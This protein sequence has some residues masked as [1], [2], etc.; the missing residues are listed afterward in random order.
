MN[1]KLI[2]I[3]INLL[4]VS[5]FLFFHTG[6][7]SSEKIQILALNLTGQTVRAQ[8]MNRLYLQHIS[9]YTSTVK[10]F[11]LLLDPVLQ[12]QIEIVAASDDEA[13]RDFVR[14]AEIPILVS[15]LI[16]DRGDFVILRIYAMAYDVPHNG[17]LVANHEVKIPIFDKISA[18]ELS[19]IVEEHTGRFLVQLLENYKRPYEF[20]VK[21]NSYVFDQTIKTGN[22]DLYA[23]ENRDDEIITFSKIQNVR[24]SKSRIQTSL[25]DGDYFITQTY[26]DESSELSDFIYGRKRETVYATGSV[27]NTTVAVIASPFLSLISPIGTPISY[28]LTSDY[29]GLGLWT[30]NNSP[31]LYIATNG[32]INSPEKRENDNKNISRYDYSTYYYSYYYFLVSGMALY[33]DAAGQESKKDASN[34]IPSQQ[35]LGDESIAVYLSIMGNGAG[36]FYK[37]Y[38]TWGYFYFHADNLLTLSSL[39]FLSDSKDYSSSSYQKTEHDKTTGYF[40]LGAAAAVRV[41]EIIHSMH[42]RFNIDNGEDLDH[43]VEAEPLYREDTEKGGMFFGLSFKKLL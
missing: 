23:I 39:Y 42:L 30:V 25:Q 32:F 16:E 31:Y 8:M 28:Y 22:Y 17:Q 13:L 21:G 15:G 6:L 14:R 26:S 37:G 38:R 1:N 20:S 7:I 41:I 11:E 24:V 19:F 29:A 5:L 33:A 10:D 3:I 9:T 12:N 2:S 40:L 35:F 4:F 43:R 18:R 27:E 36:H 34:F